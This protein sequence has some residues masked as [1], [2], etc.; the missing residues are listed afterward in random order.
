MVANH[1]FSL[2]GRLRGRIFLRW[3][4]LI[5]K[6]ISVGYLL[7]VLKLVVREKCVCN[8]KFHGAPNISP[9]GFDSQLSAAQEGGIV[10]CQR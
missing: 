9:P 6:E 2:S 8:N 5:N 4:K 1:G 7:F 10:I 3:K